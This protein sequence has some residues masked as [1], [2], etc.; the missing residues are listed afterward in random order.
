MTISP[1]LILFAIITISLAGCRSQTIVFEPSCIAFSGDRI[2]LSAA[3]FDWQRFTDARRVDD[4]GKLVDPFPGFPKSGRV[5]REGSRVTLLTE[6]GAAAAVFY[7][8]RFGGEQYLLP[9]VD[10]EVAVG[11]GRVPKCA[12]KSTSESA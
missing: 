10:Y 2:T 7:I 4:A 5:E 1:R 9:E 11:S 6:D 3:G 12:L 8:Y